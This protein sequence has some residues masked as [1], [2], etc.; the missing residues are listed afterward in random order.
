MKPCSSAA[1]RRDGT[2]RS[3]APAHGR[4]R[5]GGRLPVLRGGELHRPGATRRRCTRAPKAAFLISCRR[6]WR[7]GDLVRI[8]LLPMRAPHAVEAT[9]RAL[10]LAASFA[11]GRDTQGNEVGRGEA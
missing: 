9:G 8:H 1:L 2:R 4:G 3:V 10:T 6:S 7:D 11:T 5:G